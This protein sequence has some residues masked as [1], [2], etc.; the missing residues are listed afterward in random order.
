MAYN[1]EVAQQVR[2]RLATLPGL[3]IEEKKMSGGLA[4]LVN[5]K[6]CINV[7]GDRLMCR[8]DPELTGEVSSRK[9]FSPMVMRK[10]EYKGYCYVAPE[11]YKAR[12]DFEYWITLCLE[13]NSWG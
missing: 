11:G 2:D 7:S 3:K 9:G 1:I 12:E 6:M 5:G 10:A 8:Y 13:Y 4:F